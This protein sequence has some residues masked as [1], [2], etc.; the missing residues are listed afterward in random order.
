[1]L[2]TKIKLND[3]VEM[4]V[5]LYEDEF[6]SDCGE[7][8]KSIQVEQKEIIDIWNNGGDFVGTT[9]FC[10]ECS[11]KKKAAEETTTKHSLGDSDNGY[12]INGESIQ[13]PYRVKDEI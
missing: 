8:G 6:F 5:D 7:C 4:K 3:Q 1:M 13:N 2:Y 9:F 12:F 11:S 10:I